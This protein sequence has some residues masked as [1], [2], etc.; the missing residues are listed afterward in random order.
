MVT[1]SRGINLVTWLDA[2]VEARQVLGLDWL[3]HP[4]WMDKIVEEFIKVLRD[5]KYW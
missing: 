2:M 1:I 4:S 5:D 3:Y